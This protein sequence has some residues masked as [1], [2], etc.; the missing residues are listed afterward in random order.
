MKKI[1]FLNIVFLVI[2]CLASYFLNAQE[3]TVTIEKDPKIDELINLKKEINLDAVF[4]IQIFKC[5]SNEES[6]CKAQKRKFDNLFKNTPSE[7]EWITP[8]FRVRVGKYRT[9]LEAEYALMKIKEEFESAF[10]L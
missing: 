7:I 5:E 3:G 2:F 1:K 10:V 4:K 8:T 6:K 9:R